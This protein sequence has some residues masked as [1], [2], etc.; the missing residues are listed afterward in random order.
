MIATAVT[1]TALSFCAKILGNSSTKTRPGAVAMSQN[2][3]YP[4]LYELGV[5]K[6]LQIDNYYITNINQVDVL[7]IVYDRPKD[8]FLTSSRTY[9]FPRVQTDA[10]AESE[11]DETGV[12]LRTHPKLI[13]ALRELEEL[14]EAK[15]RKEG[16]A[17]KILSEIA[18]LEEDIAMRTE[19]IKVLA[20]KIPTVD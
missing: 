2:S 8:L 3:R 13:A 14:M 1:V 15:A 7:R 20:S 10:G 11:G 4:T 18:L 19:C 9:K 17:T 12:L 5:T 6:P 16:I